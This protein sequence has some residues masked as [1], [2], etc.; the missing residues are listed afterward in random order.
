MKS[1]PIS[2]PL[3]AKTAT[4]AAVHLQT[5]GPEEA[6]QRLDNYLLRWAKGV[7]KS[8]VYRIIRSG[9]VRVNKKRAEPTTRLVEGDI[10][11]VPP[12]R[13]AE[14]AQMAAVNT[15]QTKSR[16]QGYSDKMPILFEDE[17]LLIVNK[18]AGL[19]V[20][21]GSG[22]ALGVI[23]TLRITRPELKFLELVH[24]LDRDTSG[25]LLLA[26]KRSALVELH[27]QIREGQTDKRYYLLAHGEIAQGPGVMQLKYPLHKYLLANGE[28]RVRVDPDGLPSHTALRVTKVMKREDATITMAE[29]QLK[30][31]RTHQIRVH[32]Q[33]LGHAILGD[34]KYGF[35]DQDKAI[36]SKRLY[37]HAHLAGFTHPRTGEKMRI[38]SPLP[39]EFTAM[40]K[41][42]EAASND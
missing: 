33:K 5:I 42:F 29:A 28:R 39:A 23:E 32:L 17:A 30:T 37:L 4:A 38:E 3:A 1:E 34:D 41:T 11:R 12:V 35:E 15:A 8:H 24:R 31:G 16:A 26:K 40:M 9:E 36:K 14:P 7:P 25:V 21:G 6:G 19:A 27:R 20:H 10:V 2:K 22:I 18:P 13:I